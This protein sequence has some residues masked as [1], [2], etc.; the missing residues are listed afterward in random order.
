MPRGV[1]HRV[2]EIKNPKGE[3]FERAILFLREEEERTDGEIE[4]L[5][6]EYIKYLSSEKKKLSSFPKIRASVLLIL[7]AVLGGAIIYLIK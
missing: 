4:L 5:S 7:G 1:N 2:I 6:G 3:Y